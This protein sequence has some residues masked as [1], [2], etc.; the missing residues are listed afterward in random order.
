MST[1]T[2]DAILEQ[3]RLLT[4]EEQQRLRDALDGL[5]S[6]PPST[7]DKEQGRERSA[8]PG[9][10]ADLAAIDAIAAQ[11]GVLW[12]DDMSAVDAVREQR[13]EL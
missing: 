10:E 13:R 11:V 4:T 2:Y 12:K 5:V 8:R 9:L 7:A 1:A 3:A 6:V